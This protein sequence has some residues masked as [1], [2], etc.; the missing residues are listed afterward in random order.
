MKH[1]VLLVLVV[2][3]VILVTS[4]LLFYYFESD[5]QSKETGH[6]FTFWDALYWA[7]ITATTIGYGDI[8]P[9]TEAG[10][11]VAVATAVGGI[12]SF[13]ALIGIIANSLVEH[14]TRR[15]LGLG[16]VSAK[17]H[18]VVLGWSKIVDRLVDE[19]KAN[20]P[21]AK[22]VIVDPEAPAE[23]AEKATII[24]G[25]PLLK[26]TLIK[27]GVDKASHVIIVPRDDAYSVLLVLNTR[28][29]NN[30]AIIIA[31]AYDEDTIDLLKRAGAD[32]VLPSII[33]ASLMA[34]YVFEPSVP[35][36][37]VDLAT[38]TTG[39]AD[40]VEL[41]PTGFIGLKYMDALAK[42][43]KEDNLLIIA[44]K[45]GDKILINPPPD[46]V[47]GRTDKLIAIKTSTEQ[48]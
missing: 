19:I 27:A 7:F 47:I 21:N 2:L 15:L 36:V 11:A 10:K 5:I 20:K 46:T 8:S 30:R 6:A 44:L 33:T 4:A 38:S 9:Q 42:A 48:S 39:I 29:L 43:K 32:H 16:K 1:P 45:K 13:T 26:E 17:N 24:K 40:V 37:I 25:D 35:Q 31:T 41:P 18:I 14:T 34:S 12:A 28:R 3:A 23:L 22:I